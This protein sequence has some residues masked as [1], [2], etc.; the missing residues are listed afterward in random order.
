VLSSRGLRDELITRPEESYRL[1]CVVVCVLETSWTRRPWP[2]GGCWRQKKKKGL[3]R[4]LSSFGF[5]ISSFCEVDILA[6]WK[7]ILLVDCICV[8]FLCV[9]LFVLRWLFTKAETCSH[10]WT[11]KI[12]SCVWRLVVSFRNPLRCNL[13][14]LFAMSLQF[15]PL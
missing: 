8:I 6:I 4:L 1:W 14:Q 3:S 13:G 2:T 10:Q 11:D 5:Y 15:C 12:F 7:S 9:F